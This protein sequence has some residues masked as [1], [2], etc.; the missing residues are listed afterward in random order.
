MLRATIAVCAM[1]TPTS[2]TS[3]NLL[4]VN[5]RPRRGAITKRYT[6][7]TVAAIEALLPTEPNLDA[8]RVGIRAL[9]FEDYRG[10]SEPLDQAMSTAE[11]D[12]KFHPWP[13][14]MENTER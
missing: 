8:L 6:P 1:P 5:W 13:G 9:G 7:K 11:A 12:P 3:Q 2:F 14:A 10:V 4:L